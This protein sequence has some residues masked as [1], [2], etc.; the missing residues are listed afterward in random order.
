[1]K[2]AYI[3]NSRFPSERAHAVQMVHMCNAFAQNGHEVTFVVTNRKTHITQ[4]PEAFYGTELLFA[5]QYLPIADITGTI[6]KVPV[7]LRPIFYTV[8]RFIYIVRLLKYLRTDSFDYI[9]GRDQWLLAVLSVASKIPIVWESHEAKFSLVARFVLKRAK[10]TIV[11]SEGIL[12][13]YLQKGVPAKKM[14][15]AHDGIDDSFFLPTLS[16]NEAREKL[17]IN[18]VTKPVVMYIGGLDVWKG[19]DTLFEAGT[20]GEDRFAT[21]AIGG[22]EVELADYRTRFPKIHFLGQRPYKDLKD[23]QQAA[24]VLVI[25]NTAKNKL[26]ALYTSPLKLFAHMTSKIPIVA[27]DIPS[28]KNVLSD[29][30]AYFFEADNARSLVA[31]LA[32]VIKNTKESLEKAE[33]AYALSQHY[34]WAARARSII[35]F[36]KR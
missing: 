24:D 20:E 22:G 19:V 8:Q 35:D 23:F 1:M 26:S 34:T 25:P 21:Y 31:T 13:F 14:L 28:I 2:I 33:K 4:S 11:I 15:V 6:L 27:S 32:T 30:E 17:G 12:H 29:D 3:S 16:K 10:K 5:V 36:I 9:Y 7:V 18:M